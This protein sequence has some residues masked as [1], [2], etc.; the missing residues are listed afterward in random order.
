MKRILIGSVLA[1]VVLFLWGFVFWG[2]SGVSNA[3]M[4][5]VPDEAALSQK[6]SEALPRSGVYLLP[7][8]PAQPTEEF[9]KR[10]RAGPLAQIFYRREG[11]DPMGGGVFAAGFLHMFVSVLVMAIALNLV[12]PAT[13]SYGARVKLVL[14]AG[15]AGAIYSNLGKP[16]WWH[17]SWE[18]HLL[19]F[20]Y[21]F[22]SWVLAGLVLARFVRNGGA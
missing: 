6:L 15:L 18:Y 20:V 4:G 3:V 13:S 21:D 17:Q 2:L 16:I 14:V 12:R 1:A 10:H 22:T 5:P 9:M 11:A 7:Y 19:G 8:P